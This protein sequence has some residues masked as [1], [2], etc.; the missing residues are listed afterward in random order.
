M[1]RV[2]HR[3]PDP[4]ALD[5][6]HALGEGWAGGLGG[7]W[8]GGWPGG[9]LA[10]AL[11]YMLQGSSP[12]LE[13]DAPMQQQ[14]QRQQQQ[15]QEQPQEVQ[16]PQQPPHASEQR[17]QAWQF[18]SALRSHQQQPQGGRLRAP[19]GTDT[20]QED[21]AN[22]SGPAERRGDRAAGNTSKAGAGASSQLTRRHASLS[23][24]SAELRGND[25]EWE[26][27]PGKV[28]E[29]GRG[30][31]CSEEPRCWYRLRGCAPWGCVWG[32]GQL[33]PADIAQ[34]FAD[35]VLNRT[36]SHAVCCVLLGGAGAEGVRFQ[37]RLARKRAV[38]RWRHQRQQRG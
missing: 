3:L 28:G 29:P 33:Q 23:A 35:C 22:E 25:N 24:G 37:R 34:A 27:A 17:Q 26:P 1:R 15:Q 32:A 16:Q 18:Q 5:G 2:P 4:V 20:Q 19:R 14:Q 7:C 36:S 38:R 13:T 10:A 30:Q 21:P 6:R 8:V 11:T 9:C 12:E 31:S